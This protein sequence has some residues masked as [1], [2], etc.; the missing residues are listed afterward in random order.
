MAT[1]IM[2]VMRRRHGSDRWGSLH[3]AASHVPF[4]A[5]FDLCEACVKRVMALLELEMPKPPNMG[6]HAMLFPGGYVPMDPDDS[7]SRHL[8]SV[9]PEDSAFGAFCLQC[10]SM[11]VMRDGKPICLKCSGGASTPSMCANCG[12]A[13]KGPRPKTCTTCGHVHD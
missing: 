1:G 4:P 2:G 8:R 11:L 10:T 5:T 9:G 13:Y 12:I 7:L 6:G 3:V